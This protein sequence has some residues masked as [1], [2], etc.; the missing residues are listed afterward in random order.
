M[1]HLLRLISYLPRPLLVRLANALGSTVYFFASTLRKTAL[2]NIS[3]AFPQISRRSKKQMARHS[4]CHLGLTLLEY[5][6]LERKKGDLSSFATCLNPMQ[7]TDLEKRHGGIIYVS[8]HIANWEIP[9]IETNTRVRGIAV[10]RPLRS[11]KMTGRIN[12][13]RASTGGYIVSPREAMQTAGRRLKEGYFFGFVG[14]QGLPESSYSGLFL[15]R[16]A[17]STSA[18]A[19]LAYR[20]N[21]PIVVA[22]TCRRNGKQIIWYSPPIYPDRS[23]PLKKEVVRLSD[24]VMH[25][26]EMGVVQAPEQWMWLH[27]RWKR[28]TGLGLLKEFRYETILILYPKDPELLAPLLEMSD[29]FRMLYPHHDIA[30]CLP[31]YH[32]Q[33]PV[34]GAKVFIYED[35]SE[36]FIDTIDYKLVYN[37]TNIQGIERYY[38]KKCALM[39][40]GIEAICSKL[41]IT[42]ADFLS[43]CTRHFCHSIYEDIWEP[44]DFLRKIASAREA[45]SSSQDLSTTT[46]KMSVGSRPEVV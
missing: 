16:L 42:R 27:N 46:S 8:A 44:T 7:A 1:I 9:F 35:E 45:M 23:A 34:A 13:I 29:V 30:V 5:G 15:G 31:S 18:P 19:L 43:D 12:S 11:I 36:A 3:L 14:D 10:G 22:N 6:L 32:R 21:V 26:L 17:F 28:P 2:S 33:S 37:F 38:L 24:A 20:N 40:L 41:K 39:T 25:D 4:F